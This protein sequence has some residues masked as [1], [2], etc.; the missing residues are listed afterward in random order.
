MP[1]VENMPLLRWLLLVCVISS[2]I[3]VKGRNCRY[4]TLS[5][6]QACFELVVTYTIVKL[7][8]ADLNNSENLGAVKV[9]VSDVVKMLRALLMFM[10]I[11]PLPYVSYKNIRYF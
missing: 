5:S 10:I 2:F 7:Q 3:I 1:S 6:G 11:C 4:F 8:A 9:H